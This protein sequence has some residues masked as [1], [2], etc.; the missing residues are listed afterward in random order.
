MVIFSSRCGSSIPDQQ[1]AMWRWRPTAGRRTSLSLW[2]W[3]S[4][5]EAAEKRENRHLF[6]P[7]YIAQRNPFFVLLLCV[8]GPFVCLILL[9]ALI[10]T[11]C[12]LRLSSLPGYQKENAADSQVGQKH[13][14][15]NSRWEGI[16][17]GEVAWP[18][19]LKDNTHTMTSL[20]SASNHL[21]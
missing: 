1:V 12:I 15:P 2:C 11:D 14:E 19:S 9:L 8:P 17:E 7:P 6:P 18:T 4:T 10:C 13:E 20:L 16:Q 3:R 21:N 5:T